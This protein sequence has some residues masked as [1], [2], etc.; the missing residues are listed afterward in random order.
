VVI[1]ADDVAQGGETLLDALDFDGGR[2][3]V[4]EVLEFL[5]GG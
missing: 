5:V 1:A 3:G 2:E 4:A